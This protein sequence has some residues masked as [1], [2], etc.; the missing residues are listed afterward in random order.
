MKHKLIFTVILFSV[1]AFAFGQSC[2]VA[3]DSSKG[4]YTG[5]CKN[6]KAN[7]KGKY[8]CLNGDIYDG[9][10]KNGWF[11]GF[12]SLT[13]KNWTG[14]NE[15]ISGFWRQGI[16]IGKYEK[17]Y[18]IEALTN[19]ISE[20]TLTKSNDEVPQISITIKNNSGGASN[21]DYA[22]IPKTIMSNLQ[23]LGGRYEE[24][25]VDTLSRIASRYVLRRVT[26]PLTALLTFTTRGSLAPVQL[27]KI[28]IF[29]TGN[30]ILKASL[31]N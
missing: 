12:G 31:D 2:F 6:G 14:S 26:F 19:N 20:L 18:I 8:Q 28:E 24:L 7:G 13:R 25:Q 5:E 30:W 3:I 27:A 23:L 16:Y 17:P 21:M 4:I 9:V 11:D 10:W 1:A 22:V 15:V 29:E